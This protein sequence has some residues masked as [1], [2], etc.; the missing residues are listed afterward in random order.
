MTVLDLFLYIC[1]GALGVA[2]ALT[3]FLVACLVYHAARAAWRERK[4]PSRLPSSSRD[5]NKNI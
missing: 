4:N 5:W 3:Y 1:L 2:C